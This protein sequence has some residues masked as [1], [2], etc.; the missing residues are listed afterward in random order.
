MEVAIEDLI[1]FLEAHKDTIQTLILHDFGLQAGSDKSWMEV[2]N[3]AREQ[4]RF[5]HAD[6]R[7][8]EL[9][10]DDDALDNRL[11][12]WGPPLVAELIR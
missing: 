8:Y 5:S 2:A 4:L 10:D 12:Q 6:M 3:S 9:I 1:D 7:V 11:Y